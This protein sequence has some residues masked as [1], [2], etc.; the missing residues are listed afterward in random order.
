MDQPPTQFQ[1]TAEEQE[2]LNKALLN[3]PYNVDAQSEIEELIQQGADVNAQGEKGE[4]LLH[5][6]AVGSVWSL[7][8]AFSPSGVL[9]LENSISYEKDKEIATTLLQAGADSNI[10]DNDG[11]TPLDK[12]LKLY[13]FEI[14]H[15][16]TE[17]IND[18]VIPIARMLV[19]YGG[20][21]LHVP[22]Y[23]QEL[24]SLLAQAF[25]ERLL[26]AIALGFTGQVGE[27]L[28]VTPNVITDSDGISALAY[29]AGQGN[30][31]ILSLLFKY[32]A[33]QKD[34]TGIEQ[35]IEIVASRLRGVKPDSYEYKKY[36]N[37]I[38]GLIK[39]LGHAHEQQIVVLLRG[40]VQQ[41]PDFDIERVPPEILQQIMKE[42]LG[43]RDISK[44][45]SL[46]L[47]K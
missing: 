37:I 1:R 46:S 41:D 45:L 13:S 14:K 20:R 39:Q 43:S 16:N 17:H 35:A 8:K 12:L 23:D 36:Q 15:K 24:L 29:A 38:K 26:Q 7:L 44:L 40:A 32:L 18:Y 47:G 19:L 10:I 31:K 33:Y 34:V 3:A 6:I 4:T 5:D 2:K 22:A 11:D 25:P 21:A 42:I 27:I 30:E 9:P 28:S